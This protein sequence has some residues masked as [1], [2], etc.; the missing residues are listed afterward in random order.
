MSKE[1]RYLA[2]DFET[3]SEVDIKKCGS[4]RYMDDPS[5]ELLLG[6]FAY[7]DEDPLLIDYTAGEELPEGI[8]SDLTNPDVIKTAWN[9]AFERYAIQKHYGIYSPPE[10]WEDTMI[11]AGQCGLPMSLA[12][13]SEALG[14]GEDQAKMKEGKALI[15]YFCVPC[16][17]TKANGQRTRNL[18]EH[19]PEKWAIFKKYNG[20]DVVAERAIRKLLARWKP[21][22]EEHRFWCLDARINERG[23]R[24]DRQLASY[25]VAM[26]SRNKEELTAQAVALTGLENPKSVSQIK[27][28]LFDQEG[29]EF[30]SLNKKVI[31]DVV[32]NLKTEDA[33]K[34]MALRSE[35][36]KSSVSKYNAMLRSMGPDDHVRGC[37]QFYGANRTGRFCLTGDHEVLTPEGWVPLSE[38]Y[39][40]RIAVWSTQYETLSFQAAE[41]VRFPYS[42]EMVKIDAQRCQQ[43]STPEHKMAILDKSGAWA[44]KTMEELY[45]HQFQMAFRGTRDRRSPGDRR[46]V[47]VLVMV[48]ADGH[49]TAD[50]DLK[51]GFTKQRKI[52]RCKKLL[53]ETRVPF[54]LNEF[55]SGKTVFTIRRVDQP[56]WLREFRDKT[57]GWWLLDEDADTVIEELEHWDGYR[58]GPNS[59]QY[60]TTNRQ[61]AEVIQAICQLSG[62]SATML[63]KTRGDKHPNWS[64][65]YILNIWLTPGL[66]TG[67]RPNQQQKITFSGTVY[68][69][70]TKT[71][72]FMVRRNGVVWITGNSGKLVQ[73]QNLSKNYMD[74]LDECRELVRAGQYTT[75]KALYDGV[76]DPLSQLVRTA[77]I[78]EDGHKF[79]VSDFSAIEARVT[80]W[81]ANEEWRLRVFREGGDIYCAS[82]SQMF[83]VPVEK[84]GVNGHLRQKGKVAELALGYGGGTSALKAF[85]ADKMGMTE[86]EMQETV[87]RWRDSSPN[88]TA[89]WKA[90]EKAAIRAVVRRGSSVSK[91]G[92]ILFEFENG[93][94]FMVLP[95]GRRLA[96]WG[97]QYSE[98]RWHPDRKAL[99]YMGVDQ[100]TKKWARVE[101][102]GGKLTEN[103]WAAGTPVLTDAGWTPIENVTPDMRVWDGVEWVS[104][105]GSECQF[106]DEILFELDGLLVTGD[107]KILTS[108]GWKNAKECNGLDRAPVQL[109]D[110][111]AAERTNGLPRPQKMAGSMRVRANPDY[112]Y[113]GFTEERTGRKRNFLRMQKE[114]T[115]LKSKLNP[116][117]DFPRCI[118][119]VALDGSAL[120]G[121]RSSGLEKLWRS[122]NHCVQQVASQLREFLAGHGRKLSPRTGFRQKG[123]QPRLLPGELPLG[124]EG[125]QCPE[126]TRSQ[127]SL[128]GWPSNS[129]ERACRADR[130]RIY[131]PLVPSGS[132]LSVRK[133][134]YRSGCN[135]PVYDVKNCGPQ[136]RYVV[137]GKNGPIIA[138]NCVQATARDILREAMFHL[139]DLGYDI[140]ATVHDEVIVDEPLDSGR[141]AKDLSLAMCP[142]IPWAAGLPLRADGYEGRYYFKD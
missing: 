31:A 40:G 19:A 13:A 125:G 26:D 58:C 14:L 22:P 61:N 44:P 76:A 47:R 80:A 118:R 72:Y 20:Q 4:F 117:D 86:A 64:D 5:F 106:R 94:L 138:H 49:Y 66:S 77:M 83:H 23:V 119:S 115:D 12:G 25:A 141:T 28:W 42:G 133:T 29:Q 32:A 36:S 74:D 89:L 129:G 98:S 95:S 52:H 142:E 63:V 75:V 18:P 97:A 105:D 123:Q 126:Q 45:A 128:H 82:A 102:W 88:I 71:G 68:C 87:D 60:T 38:W 93:V 81:F 59:I 39:G 130:Y 27:K 35:L 103:C 21:L 54:L 73:F 107:H 2:A 37:F 134:D 131:H 136:H 10:Q 127:I 16:K 135:Q 120:H 113:S 108:E 11:L 3:F 6:A 67:I 51:L 111:A 84:H 124:Y 48:Q 24:I 33:R 62:R 34:F 17:P 116:R 90:L 104:N 9:C 1:K 41:S 91:V 46:A 30:P 8:R 50:G 79:M 65:A 92:N 57:F 100:Q 132:R 15:R 101:T 85:G 69:A 70:V 96:Y 99:S 122:W 109:P 55:D 137:L 56:L 121:A 7:D 112:G 114:R 78:P 43:I 110:G 53:R 140:R 139:D